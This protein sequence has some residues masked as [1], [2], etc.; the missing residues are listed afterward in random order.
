[1]K[2]QQNIDIDEFRVVPPAG[3]S[4]IE[5]DIINV[6]SSRRV[7]LEG[8]L[9]RS[10]LRLALPAMLGMY[11]HLGFRLVDTFWVGKLGAPALAS[12]G[13]SLFIVWTVFTLGE[14]FCVGS[15]AVIAR[16]IGENNLKEATEVTG[17]IFFSVIAAGLAVTAAGIITL[18][19]LVRFLG[20]SSAASA[21]AH[22][23][24]F[25]IYLGS[26]FLFLMIWT[27]SIFRANNDTKTPFI[28]QA[29]AL[30]LNAALTPALIF[31]IWIFPRMEVAGA[32]VGTV[33]S[34]FAASSV[35]LV[36]LMRRGLVPANLRLYKPS[37][38]TIKEIAKLGFPFSLSDLVFCFVYI[39]VSKIAA[40][41]GDAP[42]AALT[43]GLRMEEI[44]WLTAFSLHTAAATLTGQ[45]LGMERKDMARK[46]TLRC[47]QMGLIVIGIM[48]VIL[49]TGNKIFIGIF[50]DHAEAIAIGGAYL[51]IS[52]LSLLFMATM[53]ILSGAF[54]GS[55]DTMPMFWA[56]APFYLTRIPIALFLANAMG[57]GVN[58]IWW[59][60]TISNFGMGITIFLAFNS[61]RWMKKKV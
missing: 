47:W 5:P 13:V 6:T 60:I 59:A 8:G 19:P 20:L 48:A 14:I 12:L 27:E 32:A 44:T 30:A 51:K 2:S 4:P 23:Y 39:I 10:I 21:Y 40:G 7:S 31:G 28:I 11:I 29:C 50:I 22:D 26:V 45:Y 41:F 34:L 1:M 42:L 37:L 9:N 15:V 54:A 18:K 56:T 57:L 53:L 46:A 17:R 55:G 35:C 3:V 61:N 16:R 33:I 38:T 24:L 43:A 25:I 36:V 52:S 49:F 58:G